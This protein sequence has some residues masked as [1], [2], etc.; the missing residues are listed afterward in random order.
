MSKSSSDRYWTVQ[1][2]LTLIMGIIAAISGSGFVQQIGMIDN[3]KQERN[4]AQFDDQTAY[5]EQ[6]ARACETLIGD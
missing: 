2:I 3:L 4:E 6:R 5:W 1:N